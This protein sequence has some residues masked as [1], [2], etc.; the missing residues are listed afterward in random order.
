MWNTRARY[1]FKEKLNFVKLK[2]VPKY[3]AR[4]GQCFTQAKVTTILLFL[5]VS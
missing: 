3:M 5:R 4:I 2:N 1:G